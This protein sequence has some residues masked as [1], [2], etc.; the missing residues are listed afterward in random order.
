MNPYKVVDLK[1]DPLEDNLFK[2]ELKNDDIIYVNKGSSYI[3]KNFESK[4]IPADKE[5]S[6]KLAEASKNLEDYA[7]FYYGKSVKSLINI[8]LKSGKYLFMCNKADY[9]SSDKLDDYCKKTILYD[10]KNNT[11][12][13]GPHF[14]FTPANAGIS[15]LDNDKWLIAGGGLYKKE[16]NHSQILIDKK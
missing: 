14:L 3:F 5:T 15:K 6:Q 1:N 11:V 13:E 7:N 16:H 9:F 10:Y 2:L 12:T 4:F 8:P